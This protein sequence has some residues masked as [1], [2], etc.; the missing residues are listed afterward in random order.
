MQKLEGH[1][2]CQDYGPYSCVGR[3]YW[4]NSGL[5]RELNA[6]TVVGVKLAEQTPIRLCL[7][8]QRVIVLA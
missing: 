8:V 3:L 5:F 7:C 2:V 1:F 6:T 4:P